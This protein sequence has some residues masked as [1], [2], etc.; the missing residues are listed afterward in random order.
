MPMKPT[1]AFGKWFSTSK[2]V[3]ATGAPLVVYHGT[4][5]SFS[6][7]DLAKVGQNFDASTL[8]FYFTSA[9]KPEPLKGI[10]YGS[11]AVEY[12]KN[13]GDHPNVM[14]VYLMI[15]NPLILDDAGEWGGGARAIDVQKNDLARWAKSGDHDGIIAYD[16]TG[17]DLER[18]YVAFDAHQI[19]SAIGNNG[20]FDVANHDI[21]FS[22]VDP[23]DEVTAEAPAP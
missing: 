15:K 10:G 11:T 5:A 8:G 14:P 9:A 6:V 21:R 20:D 18:I 17:E 13:A 7:F 1:P 4:G 3:D 23:D 12:A 22:L 2:V 16:R 19:K